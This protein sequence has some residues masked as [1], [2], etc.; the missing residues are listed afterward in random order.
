M[1]GISAALLRGFRT[2]NIEIDM[3]VKTNEREDFEG[4]KLMVGYGVFRTDFP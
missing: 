2:L 3:S 1:F 4:E